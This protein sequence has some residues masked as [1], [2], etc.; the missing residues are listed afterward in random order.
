[1]ELES[2]IE[3]PFFVYGRGWASCRPERTLSRYGLQV[4]RLQVG[5]VCVSLVAK[6]HAAGAVTASLPAMSYTTTV[7]TATTRSLEPI[8][9]TSLPLSAPPP[10]THPENLS[11][12]EDARK[13]RWSAS[14]VAEDAPPLKK[15]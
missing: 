1:M 15:R 7:P 11:V 8:V 9:T 2:T 3:H 6:K 10:Q 4:Q 5:D 14:D 12:K 13:R